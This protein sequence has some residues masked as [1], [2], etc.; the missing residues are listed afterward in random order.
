MHATSHIVSVH[1]ITLQGEYIYYALHMQQQLC[2]YDIREGLNHLC[3]LSIVYMLVA[4]CSTVT[5][6]LDATA[7]D[8]PY[9]KAQC[10]V[11]PPHIC[12]HL[13]D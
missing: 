4:V 7:V 9:K 6:M 11:Y 13:R 2:T 10:K 3:I 8:V 5:W 12:E 1:A